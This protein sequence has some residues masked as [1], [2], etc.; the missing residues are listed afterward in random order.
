[1]SKLNSERDRLSAEFQFAWRHTSGF[2]AM[3]YKEGACRVVLL[4][5]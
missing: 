2:R 4:I 1:M 3:V 5:E